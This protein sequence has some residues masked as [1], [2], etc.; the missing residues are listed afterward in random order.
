MIPAPLLVAS[1]AEAVA[2]LDAAATDGGVA[3]LE[4]PPGAAGAQGIGWWQALVAEATR[5][6][7]GVTVEAVLD[8]GAAPGLALAALR[9]GVPAVRVAAD[10]AAWQ[11]LAAIATSLG[12]RILP[13]R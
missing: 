7:P 5:R 8:C 12:A 9:A 10:P 4:S 6:V 11:A 13:P 3:R 2:V 1:L